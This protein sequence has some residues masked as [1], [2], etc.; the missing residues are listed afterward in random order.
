MSP[1][2]LVLVDDHRVVTR[3]LRLFLESFPDLRVVGVAESPEGAGTSVTLRVPLM[4]P[5]VEQYCR[6]M[7]VAGGASA[8]TFGMFGLVLGLRESAYV[9][10]AALGAAA[11]LYHLRE[12]LR[13][14]RRA[15]EAQA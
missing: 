11:T 3:G 1:V 8:F 6:H 12:Y 13:W 7:R 2:R 9:L 10:P 4:R 14:K 5:E 15:N